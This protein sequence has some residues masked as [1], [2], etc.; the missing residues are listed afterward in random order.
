MVPLR[1]WQGR[2]R[3]ATKVA[4]K[5]VWSVN[6]HVYVRKMKL[7]ENRVSNAPRVVLKIGRLRNVLC[8]VPLRLEVGK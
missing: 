5:G 8:V 7:S 3:A 2:H 1:G 4:M 6:M